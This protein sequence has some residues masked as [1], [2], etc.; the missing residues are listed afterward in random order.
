MLNRRDFLKAGTGLIASAFF[1]YN[2]AEAG[3]LIG[4]CD[5]ENNYELLINHIYSVIQKI[6]DNDLEVAEDLRISQA[7]DFAVF[8]AERGFGRK[9]VEILN[10]SIKLSQRLKPFRGYCTLI[11]SAEAYCYMDEYAQAFDALAE[12]WTILHIKNMT[13]TISYHGFWKYSTA[14]EK[15]IDVHYCRVQDKIQIAR[16]LI[17]RNKTDMALTLLDEAYNHSVDDRL[18]PIENSPIVHL[19]EAYCDIGLHNK[20][21]EIAERIIPVMHIHDDYVVYSHSDKKRALAYIA[22]S[23]ADIGRRDRAYKLLDKISRLP[24]SKSREMI[25]AYAK[26]R[27]WETA[28]SLAEKEDPE[29][30]FIHCSYIAIAKQ[31]IL[32]GRKDISERAL[33]AAIKGIEKKDY[34]SELYAELLREI[35]DIFLSIGKNDKTAHLLN[36]AIGN[37]T[38][39]KNVYLPYHDGFLA[40][41]GISWIKAG[42]NNRGMKLLH[43]AFEDIVAL[44]DAFQKS[45]ALSR[46]AKAYIDNNIAIK[47]KEREIL[48]RVVDSC[49][50][51]NHA[52]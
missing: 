16:I 8:C 46:I 11:Q 15:H 40:D 49:K 34:S 26:L 44:E 29:F 3:Q 41:I 30:M 27:E 51:E 13:Y 2:Y 19:T 22:G 24:K 10:D 12:A 9:A 17:K 39:K 45:E 28:M 52:I 36:K 37:L 43:A 47:E 42:D 38:E 18:F 14:K 25:T 33:D 23:Y 7:N 31:A 35:A 32:S 48:K 21:E 20:A 6:T 4:R 1:P 50:E 5:I